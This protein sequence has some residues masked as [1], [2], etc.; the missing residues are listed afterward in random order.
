MEINSRAKTCVGAMF[1]LSLTPFSAV[2]AHS[3]YVSTR[4]AWRGL[5]QNSRSVIVLKRDVTAVLNIVQN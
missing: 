5:K 3:A 2:K 1:F 4:L